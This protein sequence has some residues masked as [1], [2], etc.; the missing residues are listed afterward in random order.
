MTYV[1]EHE[2]VQGF[3]AGGIGIGGNLLG[4]RNGD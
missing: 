4:K 2:T 1:V 3:S